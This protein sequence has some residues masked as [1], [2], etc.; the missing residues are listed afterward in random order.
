MKVRKRSVTIDNGRFN[1]LSGSEVNSFIAYICIHTNTRGGRL[2]RPAAHSSQRAEL[3]E[4]DVNI[5]LQK[6]TIKLR[7][8]FW[9]LMNL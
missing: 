5:N 4:R 9:Y 6:Q 1:H 2:I 8:C 3:I 7:S